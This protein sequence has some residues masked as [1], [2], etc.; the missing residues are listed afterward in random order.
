M[1][2]SVADVDAMVFATSFYSS[3]ANG[4][5][6]W[7]AFSAGQAAVD[8]Q[9][10]DHE[11]PYLAVADGIEPKSVKLAEVGETGSRAEAITATPFAK[12]NGWV[13]V[14]ARLGRPS[15]RR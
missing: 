6:V 5:S 10:G 9:G 8:L 15:R 7:A 4:H 13:S 14:A 11:A 2:G 1:R 3:V 12:N